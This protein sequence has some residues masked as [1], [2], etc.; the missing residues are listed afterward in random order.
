VLSCLP[1]SR[2]TSFDFRTL[3]D[4]CSTLVLMSG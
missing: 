4:F 3:A 1:L 2:E